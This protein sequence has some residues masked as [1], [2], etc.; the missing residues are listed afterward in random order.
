MSKSGRQIMEILEAFDLTRCA[1][2]AAAL[3][4]V[5]PKTVARYVAVR[6]AGG[7][8]LEPARRAKLIDPFL[9]KIEE[10]VE[11]SQGKV[12]AD[13]VHDEHVVPMGFLGERTTRRAVAAAKAKYAA[14][15]RRTYRPG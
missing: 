3:T 13:V 10:L 4:G 9:E 12:R 5:D 1:Y 7:N 8:P 6:D 15:P 14:G 2:A 11:R